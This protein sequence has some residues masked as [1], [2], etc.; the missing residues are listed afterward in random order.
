[1]LVRTNNLRTNNFRTLIRTGNFGN[2]SYIIVN[3]INI[4][5]Q[6]QKL[7]SVHDFGGSRGNNL[8]TDSL[9]KR[10]DHVNQNYC[11]NQMTLSFIQKYSFTN[12]IAPINIQT[13]SSFSYPGCAPIQRIVDDV[14]NCCLLGAMQES[15]TPQGGMTHNINYLYRNVD[16]K[17]I[18]ELKETKQLIANFFANYTNN[19]ENGTNKINFIVDT[20]GDI[21][22][23]LKST[24]ETDNFAY[25]LTQESAHDSAKGKPTPLEPLILNQAYRGNGYVEAFK[26]SNAANN[27]LLQ[28]ELSAQVNRTYT[29]T[30]PQFESNFEINF[31]GMSFEVNDRRR[32]V[33]VTNVTY[34]KN[35]TNPI[36]NRNIRCELN[37]L[38]HPT[39]VPQITKEVTRIIKNSDLFL[40]P[41]TQD[42]LANNDINGINQFYTNFNT[43]TSNGNTYYSVNQNADDLDFNFTKKRAGDGLQAKIVELMNSPGYEGL[44]CYKMGNGNGSCNNVNIFYIRKAVLVTIDRVLFSY[45][46]KNRIP[47]IYSGT[48]CILLFKPLL[49]QQVVIGGTLLSMSLPLSEI[50]QKNVTNERKN[51][52]N[53]KV[54]IGG[55]PE[56]EMAFDIAQIPFCL[57]KFIPRILIERL[58]AVGW[59][60]LK[61]KYCNLSDNDVI[62]RY[63]NERSCIYYREYPFRRATDNEDYAYIF[64]E[65]NGFNTLNNN[66]VLWFDD[67]LNVYKDNNNTFYIET[68]YLNFRYLPERF[69]PNSIKAVSTFVIDEILH[70]IQQLPVVYFTR[71]QRQI[72]NEGLNLNVH[73]VREYLLEDTQESYLDYPD[74]Y[75]GGDHHGGAKDDDDNVSLV[76][77]LIPNN[78]KLNVFLNFFYNNDISLDKEKLT[79]NN[80]LALSAYLSIFDRY[81]INMCFDNDKY[82]QDFIK[83][84]K[85]L[86]E[87]SN[88]TSMYLFFK[89]LLEDFPEQHDKICY[90]LMEYF[91][92]EGDGNNNYFAIADDLQTQIYYIYCDEIV[93]PYYVNEII[94]Q[95]ISDG[96]INV[97]DPIF[98]N[99]KT[100]FEELYSRINEKN[101][102]ITTYLNHPNREENIQDN[103]ELEEYIKTYFNMYGFM[104]MIID[105][106]DSIFEPEPEPESESIPESIP[107][108][109]LGSVEDNAEIAK[110]I[111]GLSTEERLK[112][113]EEQQSRSASSPLSSSSIPK[114]PLSP[115]DPSKQKTSL[116][117]STFSEGNDMSNM[118]TSNLSTNIG[119]RRGGK[120]KKYRS[121]QKRLK[122]K[123]NK[124]HNMRQ[125]PKTRRNRKKKCKKNSRRK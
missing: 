8:A 118:V 6:I 75:L 26:G 42:P 92:N 104:N 58:N 116:D 68:I 70:I 28:N 105:F 19:E 101:I 71:L 109:T 100:Y 81:E 72:K 95:N 30:N 82:E 24:I 44:P 96:T 76:K 119:N 110:G 43:Y 39:N 83:I 67:I 121:N 89:F 3:N 112:R 84:S 29:N 94:E 38:I 33:F 93:R 69:R 40:D 115:F 54:Q 117:V 53:K 61:T 10:R 34:I 47:A 73:A 125:Q 49:A 65:G 74:T 113:I 41:D 37:S 77:L 108:P 27:Q 20:P 122:S 63:G 18:N 13:F 80:F 14:E 62:T 23:I 56:S 66:Y 88:K 4:P 103:I 55:R 46:I 107:V 9:S 50:K 11:Y 22:K 35:N 86:P 60:I 17:N 36:F 106:M 2:V 21:T 31:T 114:N 57:F 111:P 97:E 32:S 12:I 45:C 7:D 120:T 25:I 102:E 79:T 52:F 48:N 99:T 1:M 87:V 51:L 91:I 98:I 124:K 123:K 5:Q 85:S 78:P 90:G 15:L 64:T 59:A 16:L